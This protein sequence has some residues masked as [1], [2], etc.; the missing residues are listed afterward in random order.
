MSKMNCLQ[1]LERIFL[2]SVVGAFLFLGATTQA[3]AQALQCGANITTNTTLTADLGPCSGVGLGVDGAPAHVTLN[4]N[5][6]TISGSGMGTGV[7]VGSVSFGLTIKGPGKIT[8][9]GLGIDMGG[10]GDV[11][12]YDLLLK[13]NQAGM[14]IGNFRSGSSRVLNNVIVGGK[15]GQTGISLGNV[16]NVYIYKNTISEFAI[17]VQMLAETTSVVD[18]NLI[19]GNHA[20]IA[21]GGGTPFCYNIRGNVVAL[22]LGT[23]V[24]IG[25][26]I[27]GSSPQAV[28]T[29]IQTCGTVEDNT[30]TLNGGSGIAVAGGEGVFSA[31]VQDNI[32]SFNKINGISVT[33]IGLDQ[34]IGNRVQDNGTDLFWDGIA[35]PQQ[36][37]WFQNIFNTS[38]PAT[39]PPCS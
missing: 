8:N 27:G 12:I 28:P 16:D 22:N 33:G 38:S 13:G 15:Q 2:M 25:G 6:H 36:V 37:C 10:S 35:P 29:T 9:F 4:L 18:E 34:V 11:L 14:A 21:A 3:S 7:T 1:M 5:G 23:G 26:P 32:V 24:Q 17:A 39:L 20:G 19:I 31:L 30:I